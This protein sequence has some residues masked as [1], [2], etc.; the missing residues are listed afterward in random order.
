MSIDP[1]TKKL[2]ISLP[3]IVILI[4]L[5]LAIAIRS[6]ILISY[7]RLDP[8]LNSDFQ[9]RIGFVWSR[10]LYTIAVF[11][12]C[13]AIYVIGLSLYTS[14]NICSVNYH[15]RGVWL[16]SPK[17]TL[18]EASLYKNSSAYLGYMSRSILINLSD[19][20]ANFDQCIKYGLDIGYFGLRVLWLITYVV[21]L[22]A[23]LLLIVL[24]RVSLAVDKFRRPLM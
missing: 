14:I 12:M 22:I 9:G 15:D 21:P 16:L 7:E 4:L 18:E 1:T 19:S 5:S 24:V 10:I 6:A 23:L 3:I 11:A 17:Q 20:T 2:F 13:G 8:C